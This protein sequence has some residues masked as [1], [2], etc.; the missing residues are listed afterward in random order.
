MTD[1]VYK[2]IIAGGRD[3]DDYDMLKSEMD[4]YLF[5]DVGI[6]TAT[7][8][9]P[10]EVE[11]VTG[12]ARGADALGERYAVENGYLVIYF[13]AN[14][15]QHGRAAG[16]I[17]NREMAEYAGT[18]V[19]FWDGKSRGSKNMIDTARELSLDTHVVSY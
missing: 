15:D 11:V 18:C 2:I 6:S 8:G 16:P 1:M 5:E 13:P 9:Y 17:R 19:V 7:G 3:F 4:K 14:W 12:C 10:D